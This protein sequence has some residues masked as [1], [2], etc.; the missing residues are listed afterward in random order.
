[1]TGLVQQWE[2]AGDHRAIFLG[3]YTMMTR[4]MLAAL[5]A[6]R[7]HDARWVGALL[8][9]FA[10]YYFDALAAC[11]A[12]DPAAPAVWRGAF[13]AAGHPETLALQNLLLGVNAHINFDLAFAVVDMLAPEWAG[14]T[15]DERQARHEDFCQVNHIIAE[16]VNAVQDEVLERY[17][18]AMDQVDKLLGPLDEWAVT[19]LIADWRDEVWRN[20]LEWLA[21]D[22]AAARAALRDEVEAAALRWAGR[23]AG[24]PAVPSQ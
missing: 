21:A 10:D 20:V 16:T 24:R 7:F 14:L 17:S 15:Q 1:M 12:G 18:P 4:N 2:Q 22:D 9:H 23:M 6:G 13:A 11:E 5:D 8:E 19:H 3:C